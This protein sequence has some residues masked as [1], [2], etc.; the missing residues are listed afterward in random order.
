[1]IEFKSTAKLRERWAHW[2]VLKAG[3][4]APKSPTSSTKPSVYQVRPRAAHRGSLLPTKRN[5]RPGNPVTIRGSRD[6]PFNRG[7][8][9][10]DV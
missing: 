9:G 1:M 6:L 3:E 8:T 2:P 7:E 5:V 10:C 4:I